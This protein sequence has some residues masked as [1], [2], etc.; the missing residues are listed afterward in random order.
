MP[1]G[2]SQSAW[3]NLRSDDSPESLEL[4]QEG[5]STGNRTLQVQPQPQIPLNHAVAMQWFMRAAERGFTDAF[6]AISVMYQSGN[7]VSEAYAA[8]MKWYCRG[9]KLGN[10]DAQLNIGLFYRGGLGVR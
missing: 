5:G 3:G 2:L 4:N 6:V 1:G 10:G 8:A 7:G 9:A